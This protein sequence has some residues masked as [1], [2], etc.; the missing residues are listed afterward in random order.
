MVFRPFV[1][2]PLAE[3]TRTRVHGGAG[4]GEGGMDEQGKGNAIA[5][6]S[7]HFPTLTVEVNDFDL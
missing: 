1:V 2:M 6:L 3:F 7:L 4:R 5:T